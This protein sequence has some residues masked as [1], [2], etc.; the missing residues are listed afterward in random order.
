MAHNTK[1]S[2]LLETSHFKGI[3]ASEI[4]ISI[5]FAVQVDILEGANGARELSSVSC[6]IIV[7][8]QMVNFV[9]LYSLPA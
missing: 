8:C 2:F 3:C 9:V 4:E 5:L 7:V 6:V 1:G